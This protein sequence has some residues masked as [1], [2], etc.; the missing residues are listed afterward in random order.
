MIARFALAAALSASAVIPAFATTP[1]APPEARIR[2]IGAMLET[3]TDPRQG[4]YI[5]AYDG[6]W[7]YARVRDECP[8]LTASARLGLN[9]SPGGHFDRNSTISADGWRCF[10]DSVTLSEGPPSRRH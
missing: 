10:V 2:N 7:F 4:V 5:R 6:R 1:E 3:V 8:R 9:G